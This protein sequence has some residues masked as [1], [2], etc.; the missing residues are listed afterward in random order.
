M[1]LFGCILLIFLV[2]KNILLETNEFL[3]NEYLDKYVDLITLNK[4]TKK[5]LYKTQRHHI[6]PKCYYK[7]NNL[8]INNEAN[9]L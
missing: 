5:E 4:F 1:S 6:I 2:L 3:D 9:N 8:L 7:N